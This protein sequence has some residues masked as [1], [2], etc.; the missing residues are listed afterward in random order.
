MGLKETAIEAYKVK[1]RQITIEDMDA[2][3]KLAV[4][5]EEILKGRI[6]ERFTILTVSKKP[7]ETLFDV[8]G[9]KFLVLDGGVH[10]RKICE[11][12]WTEYD[13]YLPSTYNDQN[14]VMI[15]IGYILLTPHDILMH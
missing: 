15:D 1:E 4:R 11:K 5:T 7:T 13:K 10:I 9:I 6:G 3:D 14:R 8:D 2:A 12:C